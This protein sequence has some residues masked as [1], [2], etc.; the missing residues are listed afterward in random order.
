MNSGDDTTPVEDAEATGQAD[1]RLAFW[2][3]ALALGPVAA[4]AVVGGF[5]LII[6]MAQILGGPPGG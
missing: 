5:G 3:I 1:E 2:A 4:V 6:W